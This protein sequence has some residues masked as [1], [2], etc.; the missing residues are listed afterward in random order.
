MTPDVRPVP[1]EIADLRRIP[2]QDM[3][4]L[5]ALT[6]EKAVAR[7]LPCPVTGTVHPGAAFSS[8]I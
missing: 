1:S 3:P 4:A 2:L 5:D 6:L 7:V 8:A